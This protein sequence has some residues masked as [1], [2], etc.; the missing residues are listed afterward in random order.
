MKKKKNEELQS[1]REFFKNAAKKALPFVA[2][3]ALASNPIIAKAAETEALGCKDGGCFTSCTGCFSSCTG[4]CKYSCT[5]SCKDYCQGTCKGACKGC[6][7]SCMN[8]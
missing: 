5:G 2:A 1:R 8:Y 6:S 4:T 3:L 7:G